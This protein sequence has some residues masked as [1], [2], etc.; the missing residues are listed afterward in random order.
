MLDQVNVILVVGS[1]VFYL[2]YRKRNNLKAKRAS[3]LRNCGVTP[4]GLGG[5]GEGVRNKCLASSAEVI[6]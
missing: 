5:G 1:A 3:F 4:V 2:S 6:P